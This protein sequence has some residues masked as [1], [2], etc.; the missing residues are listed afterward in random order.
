MPGQ[1]TIGALRVIFGANTVAFEKGTTKVD[2][3]MKQTRRRLGKLSKKLV[4]VG[5]VMSIGLTAPLAAL[6]ATSFKTAAA[7]EELQSAFDVT[8]KGASSSMRKWAEETGDTLQRSTQEIQ[9]SAVAFASLF[10]KAFDPEQANEMTKT[11]SIL[12]QDLASFRDLSN[13]VAQQKLFSGLTGEAEPLKAVGVFLNEAALK[14][15]LLELGL[16]K[17]NGAYTDQQKIVGRAAL[18]QEQLAEANGDV[19]RTSDSAT[20]QIKAAKAAFN[21]LQVVIGNQ[22]IP[23]ITPLVKKL[24][25]VIQKFTNLSP[26]MQKI[27]GVSALILAAVGPIV[28]VFGTLIGVLAPLTAGIIAVTGATTALGAAMAIATA[29]IGILVA[30]LVAG[31]I[32]YKK[33]GGAANLAK[34]AHEELYGLIA[35]NQALLDQEKAT[36]VDMAKARLQEAKSTREQIKA[37]LDLARAKL[38]AQK[39]DLSASVSDNRG[40]YM[41]QQSVGLQLSK[42]EATNRAIKD[43]TDALAMNQAAQA[44]LEDQIKSLANV[45][46]TVIVPANKK[47]IETEKEKAKRIK[48]AKKAMAEGRAEAKRMAEAHTSIVADTKA[49][50]AATTELTAALSQSQREYD[51]TAATIKILADGYLGT[52][53]QARELAVRLVEVNAAMQNVET[54]AEAAKAHKLVVAELKKEI[55]DNSTLAAAM[56]ISQHEY[57]VVVEMLRLVENGYMGTSEEARKLA[58]ESVKSSKEVSDAADKMGGS[59]EDAFGGAMSAFDRLVNGLKSG[60]LISVIEG[61]F[62]VLKQI[63]D[64]TGGFK[65]GGI[66]FGGARAKGGPVAGG[67]SYL[68]GERGPEIFSPT[69]SGRI[70]PNHKMNSGGSIAQIVPSPYF[71]VVVDG[72]VVRGSAL[73][74]SGITS[75]AFRDAGQ[76]QAMKARNAL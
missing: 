11:F 40:V 63:A 43:G 38:L 10:N 51:I 13:S 37:E 42:I 69:A 60:N 46:A 27:I 76:N 2:R 53:E 5:K 64:L 52:A 4:S 3:M 1:A 35:D 74:A 30:A 22:L 39:T 58:E 33:W 56:R 9:E 7:F 44:S 49:E 65:I 47:H 8:F 16:K 61:I 29:P 20:N 66:E 23:I 54:Q 6:G 26:K 50:I 28:T 21:E 57:M 72:R 48:D 15:K 24:G 17:V 62:G 59:F 75:Q 73:V 41:G 55:E 71:D 12:T 31:T 67:K 14:T 45:V 68:V 36:T 34:A 70:I 19:I 18:I 32:V 25:E